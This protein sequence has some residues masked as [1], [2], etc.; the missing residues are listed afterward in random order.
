MKTNRR[1]FLSLVPF[2]PGVAVA[3]AVPEKKADADAET[4]LR[5]PD[6]HPKP[7]AY[8]LETDDGY[9]ALVPVSGRLISYE[10]CEVY[11]S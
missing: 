4:R 7:T 11:K 2:S 5:L 9:Q 8:L 10:V 3:M 6:Y 1:R